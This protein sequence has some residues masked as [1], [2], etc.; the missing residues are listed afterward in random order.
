M[1]YLIVGLGNIGAEYAETRHNIGFKVLDAFAE[2]SNAVFGAGRYGAVCETKYKGRT[3]VLLKPSTYMNLSGKA[4]SYWMQA[5]KIEPENL[6]VVVDDIAL[7]FGTLRLR[8][9]GSDGGHNGLKNIAL[10]LGSENY[11]RLRFG[12]GGDF[13]RGHQVDY[14]LGEWTDQERSGMPPRIETACEIIR[15]FGLQGVERTMNAYNKK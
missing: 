1:K 5:G 15:S 9:R 14:V 6:L 7:P 13:P 11:A 3:F 2:A 4:V 8:A 10:M 12:V